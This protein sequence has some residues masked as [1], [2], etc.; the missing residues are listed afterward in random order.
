M[1]RS[2]VRQLSVSIPVLSKSCKT[3]KNWNGNT[4]VAVN[5]QPPM[6]VSG[7]HP[8]CRQMRRER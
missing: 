2:F 5:P 7:R 8:K 6:A 4:L 3:G 1:L